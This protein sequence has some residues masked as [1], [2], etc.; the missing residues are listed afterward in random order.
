MLLLQVTFMACMSKWIPC[1]LHVRLAA[2]SEQPLLRGSQ[3]LRQCSGATA[4]SS[5]VC[6]WSAYMYCTSGA[7]VTVRVQS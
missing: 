4:A 3:A 1:K 5:C 2:A 7:V 6:G